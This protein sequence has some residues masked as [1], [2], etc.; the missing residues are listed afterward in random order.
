MNKK[1]LRFQIMLLLVGSL[2]LLAIIS[3]GALYNLDSQAEHTLIKRDVDMVI[4]KKISE[5]KYLFGHGKIQ[6]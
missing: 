2:S 5:I 4:V 3:L 1:S 6:L